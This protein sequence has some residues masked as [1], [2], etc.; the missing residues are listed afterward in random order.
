MWTGNPNRSYVPTGCSVASS[1]RPARTTS[2]SR[3]SRLHSGL[4]RWFRSLQWL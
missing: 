4:E 3:T 2:N 1:C